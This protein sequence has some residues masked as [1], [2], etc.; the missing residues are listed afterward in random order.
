MISQNYAKQTVDNYIQVAQEYDDIIKHYRNE[1]THMQEK[2]T[3]LSQRNALLE[4]KE[5]SQEKSKAS[6]HT[7]LK[8]NRE[9]QTT[10]AMQ[11][12]NIERRASVDQMNFFSCIKV[13]K[14][15]C[16]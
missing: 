15:I 14:S 8:E 16:G 11:Q 2:I 10:I 12:K 5:T 3:E 13:M 6:L 1:N 9:L 7:L 4:D